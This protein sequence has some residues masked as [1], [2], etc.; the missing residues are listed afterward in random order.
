MPIRQL[1]PEVLVP[2]REHAGLS[3]SPIEAQADFVP[4]G[5]LLNI[6]LNHSFLDGLKGAMIVGAWAK[7]CRE[8][9]TG[10]GSVTPSDL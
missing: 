4:G 5:C 2:P 7:N 6:C 8:L 3:S 9:Q 10:T 1:R